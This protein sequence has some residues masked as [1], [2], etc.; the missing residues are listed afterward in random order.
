VTSVKT[1]KIVFMCIVSWLVVNAFMCRDIFNMSVQ[2]SNKNYGQPCSRRLSGREI[3][4]LK[5]QL[6]HVPTFRKT[7]CLW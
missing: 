3:W 1:Q 2:M 7:E 6:G 5:A 4:K